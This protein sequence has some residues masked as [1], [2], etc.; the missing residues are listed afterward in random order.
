ML[1][2]C[3][4]AEAIQAA[5]QK[6]YE[7]III[8]QTDV[9]VLY[10]LRGRMLALGILKEEEIKAAS[11][12]Y[13]AVDPAK[14]LLKAIYSN[15]DPVLVRFA[16]LSDDEQAEFRDALDQF[17]RA[18]SFLSQVMPFTDEDLERLYVYGKALAACLPSQATG[19][20]DIG[21]DVVLTHLRIES[22]GAH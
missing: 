2:F 1:D 22:Q 10:D 19:S 17:I 11:D 7:G 5:F 6:Y 16:E 13:F 8:E 18:Y 4:E 21:K 20:L 9:N 3:N 12:A 15:I 14:R